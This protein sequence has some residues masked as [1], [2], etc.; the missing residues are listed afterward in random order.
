MVWVRRP[1]TG[2][3][4]TDGVTLARHIFGKGDV[5]L[6]FD[7]DVIV[8]MDPAEVIELEVPRDRGRLARDSFHHATVAAERVNAVPEQLKPRPVVSRRE[9]FFG[10][11][12][13][14]ARRHALSQRTSGG[15]YARCPAVLG[16][17]GAAAPELAE[18]F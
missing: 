10:N 5:G 12:H 15:L 4:P 16:V 9:P 8:V 11:G 17:P 13:A 18:G 1:R 2:I 14:Y 6:A 7:G 3:V